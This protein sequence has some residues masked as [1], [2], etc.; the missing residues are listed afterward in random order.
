M[1]AQLADLLDKGNLEAHF[2]ARSEAALLHAAL[3]ESAAPLLARIEALDHENAATEL[4]WF[5]AD[6]DG[7]LSVLFASANTGFPA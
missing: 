7:R 5:L 1:L 2:L 3:G 4:R 6:L